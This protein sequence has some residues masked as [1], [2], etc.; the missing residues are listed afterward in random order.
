MARASSFPTWP[1]IS[2]PQEHCQLAPS[3]PFSCQFPL[4]SAGSMW[5]GHLFRLLRKAP[6]TISPHLWEAACISVTDMLP[7]VGCG[8][9]T[10]HPG[11]L[12]GT[13]GYD[14][15]ILLTPGGRLV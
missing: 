4:N 6:P 8:V 11:H 10:L 13:T 12:L 14:E 2:C 7:P 5:T 1:L 9:L 3:H 15:T